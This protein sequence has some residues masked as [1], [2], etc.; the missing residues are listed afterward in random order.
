MQVCIYI[1]ERG[2]KI[3]DIIFLCIDIT[4]NQ[5]WLFSLFLLSLQFVTHIESHKNVDDINSII[6]FI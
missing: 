3:A 4:D 6:P 5:V 1:E 2:R